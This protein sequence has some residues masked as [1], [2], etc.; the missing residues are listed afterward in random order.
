[1]RKCQLTRNES[2]HQ[3]HLE[4]DQQIK[5]HDAALLQ[6]PEDNILENKTKANHTF[7]PFIKLLSEKNTAQSA[8]ILMGK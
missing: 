8:I 7:L 2:K 3:T 5:F 1:M 6:V 4:A